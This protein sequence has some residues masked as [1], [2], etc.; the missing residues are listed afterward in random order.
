VASPQTPENTVLGR[1]VCEEERQGVMQEEAGG[2]AKEEADTVAEMPGKEEHR[3]NEEN[4][5]EEHLD[6]PARV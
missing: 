1:G 5:Q 6:E 3:S 2:V 4:I